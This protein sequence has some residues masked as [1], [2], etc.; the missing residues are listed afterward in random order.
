MLRQAKR[1]TLGAVIAALATLGVASSAPAAPKGIF[2]VFAQCPTGTPGVTLCQFAQTTSGEFSIGSAKVPINKTITIQGGAIPTG[3]PENPREYFLVPAKNGESLSKTE[4]NVPGGLLGGA[5]CEEIKGR[6]FFEKIARIACKAVFE[7]KATAI[8]ATTELVATEKDPPIL[9][10]V[11]LASEEGAALTLP[12]R[13]HLKNPLL[14]SACYIGSATD[15]IQLHLTT[16]TSGSLHGK[17]GELETLEETE[18]LQLRIFENSL[19]DNTFAAPSAEGCGEF[20]FFKGYLDSILDAK[21]K[22]PNNPGANTAIL[23]GE[24]KA[25]TP[26]AILASEKS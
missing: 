1:V 17:R 20:S 24:L 2:S 12:V 6:G 25:A 22:I 4:L 11:A 7:S 18:Q 8:T 13:I 19:I 9:N 26:E 23:N 14:G 5:N 16:G 3:N 15:P 21:L 10:I